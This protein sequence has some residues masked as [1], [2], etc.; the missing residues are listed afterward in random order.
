MINIEFEI[1]EVIAIILFLEFA[2][3]PFIPGEL[4]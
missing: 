4:E 1:L 2:K 3:I